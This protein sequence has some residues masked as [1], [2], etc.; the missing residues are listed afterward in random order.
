MSGYGL[1]YN[2]DS[3]VKC[4]K[5][6]QIIEESGVRII[7]GVKF[8]LLRGLWGAIVQLFELFFNAK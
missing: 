5:K 4:L 1:K 6:N 2:M 3:S 8:N 7:D